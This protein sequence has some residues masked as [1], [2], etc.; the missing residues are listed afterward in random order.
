MHE[1]ATWV[2]GTLRSCALSTTI[3]KLEAL[4]DLVGITRVANVTGLDNVGIPVAT[5]IRP[6][7]KHLTTSQGKGLSFE[8]AWIS[9]VMEAIEAFHAEN[10]K[11]ALLSGS[12]DNLK[13]GYP[14]IDP[15]K[16]PKST[17]VDPALSKRHLDWIDAKHL[18]NWEDCYLPRTLVSLDST[19]HMPEYSL[20]AVNSNGLAAGNTLEEATCH[21]LF[22][23]I[24]R[25]ALAH[26]AKLDSHERQAL[27]LDLTSIDSFHALTLIAQLESAM[28][29]VKLWDVTPKHG[30]PVYHCTVSDKYVL[31]GLGIFRGSGCHAI[32][33]IALLRAITE[34]AQSRLT[35]ISGS[36]DD[37]FPSYYHA[38]RKLYQQKAVPSGTFNFQNRLSLEVPYQFSALISWIISK[39]NI[40]GCDDIYI[41]NHT[42][43]DLDIPVVHVFA[44][45]LQYEGRRI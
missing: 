22:E 15:N 9:A 43:T 14:V 17:F 2:D 11:E 30:I 25:D 7:A 42:K 33:E 3:T 24:E 32:K 34:A 41:V 6:N 16:F 39:L 38:N 5:A 29:E 13:Q 20:F 21:A 26:F 1:H 19:K 12:Y 40:Y 36:R 27:K 31:R 18:I 28:Q 8:A 10:P 37:I 44:P 4:L 35:L 45:M 23:L